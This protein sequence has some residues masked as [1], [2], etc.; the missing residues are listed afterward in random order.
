MAFLPS[1][2]ASVLG[3]PRRPPLT[4]V[5]ARTAVLRVQRPPWLSLECAGSKLF[6]AP[7]AYEAPADDLWWAEGAP[8][9]SLQIAC[10]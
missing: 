2:S 8:V 3:L 1:P 7:D 9:Q 5:H 10:R 4:S 6:S